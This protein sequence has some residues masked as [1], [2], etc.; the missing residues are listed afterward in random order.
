MLR[1]RTEPGDPAN[2]A[3]GAGCKPGSGMRR[4]SYEIARGSAYEVAAALDAAAGLGLTS[5]EELE[6]VHRE[7]SKLCWL[8]A[9]LIAA[10]ANR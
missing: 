4:R 1:F 10:E 3:E 8:L 2:I 5:P 6:P 9:R 7:A